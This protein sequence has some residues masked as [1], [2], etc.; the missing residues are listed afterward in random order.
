MNLIKVVGLVIA[1][2]LSGCA[3][4]H[5]LHSSKAPL[6]ELSVLKGAEDDSK[7]L[8]GYTS[9]QI[10]SVNG[11]NVHPEN[12]YANSVEVVPGKYKVELGLYVVK[13]FKTR[14]FEWTA[15]KGKQYQIKF[16]TGDSHN[17]DDIL[18]VK[19][20]WLEDAVSGAV[21]QEISNW[22]K[23]QKRHFQGGPVTIYM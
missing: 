5:K 12:M 18:D 11:N 9:I 7:A 17:N 16:E 21:I 6:T 20:V 8:Y 10:R 15:E 13:A 3:S 14:Y 22:S 19:R 4:H 23:T 2:L 1:I